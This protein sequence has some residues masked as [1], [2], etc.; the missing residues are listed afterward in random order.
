MIKVAN[1][2]EDGRL[3]GPQIRM[4][5]VARRL[6]A[7]SYKT[8]IILPN[9]ENKKFKDR[10][11]EYKVPFKEIPLHRLTKNKWHL[12]LFALSFLY[13]VIYLFL[14]LRK[15]RFDIL[16][17]SGGSWQW[18]GAIAGKLAGCKVVWHLN[19]T[20]VPSY[21]KVVFKWLANICADAFIIAGR[22]VG[23]Y[24]MKDNSLKEKVVVEIQAPVDSSFFEPSNIAVDKGLLGYKGIKVVTIANVNP[25]KG[26]ET[27]IKTA[28]EFRDSD[29]KVDFFIV[30]PVYDSQQNYFAELEELV[31]KD[32]VNNI[33]FLGGSD[34][35]RGVL[36]GAD[37]YVCSSIFEASPVSVWEAM[38]MCKPVVSTDVGD[39]S[40]FVEN[41]VNGFIV[42]VKDEKA[43][44][45]ALSKLVNSEA[46]RKGF[47]VKA[48]SV[49]SSLLDISWCVAKHEEVYDLLLER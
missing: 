10:L 20:Q 1:I 31:A 25:L 27:F 32:K 5:E 44:A 14:Y 17:V 2:I 24:Y 3:A 46:L 23:E 39:V 21:I 13:E 8:T 7:E 35:V 19:D 12:F 28:N 38:S 37:I 43:M 41:G 30:G 34:D 49:A 36:K 29:A 33:H 22:R 11:V 6:N 47:G 40:R 26:L 15:E 42:D 45:V 18:K 16:H 48:R 4:L 9:K